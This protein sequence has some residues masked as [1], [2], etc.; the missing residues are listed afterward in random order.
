VIAHELAVM[1]NTGT[2]LSLLFFGVAHALAAGTDPI[3]PPLHAS[4]YGEELRGRPMANGKP[5]DPDAFTTASWDHPLGTRLRVTASNGN[6]VTVVV[7]DR[8][9]AKRLLAQGRVLDLSKAAFTK[10]ADPR[11]GIVSL[12]HIEVLP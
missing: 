3:K 5:F 10:L 11:V 6:T 4:W 1:R 7:T 2:R 9:P 8:G 12:S